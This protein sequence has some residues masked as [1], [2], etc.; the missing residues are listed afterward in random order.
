[1]PHAKHREAVQVRRF[2]ATGV[3]P[4]QPFQRPSRVHRRPRPRGPSGVR[5]TAREAPRARVQLSMPRRPSAGASSTSPGALMPPA[6]WQ[7]QETSRTTSAMRTGRS[8]LWRN[9]RWTTWKQPPTR[10]RA[11]CPRAWR[12]RCRRA[13]SRFGASRPPRSSVADGEVAEQVDV[14]LVIRPHVCE[15][16]LNSTGTPST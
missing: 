8:S 10:R 14:G 11:S 5:R 1:M 12:C 3:R 13:L 15:R 9:G 2:T 16:P 6:A 4:S 7:A